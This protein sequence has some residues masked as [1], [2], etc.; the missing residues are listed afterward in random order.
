ML[1]ARL[2]R[3]RP[4][5]MT[6]FRRDYLDIRRELQSDRLRDVQAAFDPTTATRLDSIGVGS[7]WRCLVVGA[8]RGSIVGWLSSRVGPLGCVVTVDDEPAASDASAESI[9]HDIATGPVSPGGYD[10]AHSRHI[11]MTMN[12]ACA[13]LEN[14]IESLRPGGW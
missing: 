2:T 11:L 3:G 13:A 6:G 12:N 10:L 1:A 7:G 4:V 9:A 8:G 5:V 14:M